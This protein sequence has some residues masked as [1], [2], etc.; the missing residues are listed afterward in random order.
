MS[1]ETPALVR[2]FRVGRRTVTITIPKPRRGG[3][4]S[5]AVEWAPNAPTKLSCRERAQYRRG[6]DSVLV[7]LARE[8]NMEIAV[9]EI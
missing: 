9:C 1:A 6:R 3:M 4:V 2:S 5:V 7:E 8:I